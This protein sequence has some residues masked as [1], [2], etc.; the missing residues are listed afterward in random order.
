MYCI[1]MVN[2]HSAI[3]CIVNIRLALCIDMVHTHVQLTELSL[4]QHCT[5]CSILQVKLKLFLFIGSAGEVPLVIQL[6]IVS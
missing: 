3:I 1:S 5:A 4:I 2:M 6:W